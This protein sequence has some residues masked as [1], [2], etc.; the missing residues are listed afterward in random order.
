M[1]PMQLA[2]LNAETWNVCHFTLSSSSGL[3]LSLSTSARVI[4]P[5]LFIPVVSMLL[6]RQ[7]DQ[8]LYSH[9][10]PEP[11]TCFVGLEILVFM[12]ET[13]T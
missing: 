2:M 12:M 8:L 4:S 10:I 9:M 5:T 6:G 1:R 13:L 7:I 3:A 11:I